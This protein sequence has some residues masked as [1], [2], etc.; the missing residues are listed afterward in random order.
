MHEFYRN[1]NTPQ[2]T[3]ANTRTLRHMHTQMKTFML[4]QAHTDTGT[5]LMETFMFW[6]YK[7]HTK[8]GRI[9]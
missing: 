6:K 9:C 2:Y 4:T 7:I 5:H 8:A 3:R 1:M